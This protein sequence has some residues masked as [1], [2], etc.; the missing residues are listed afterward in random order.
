MWWKKLIRFARKWNRFFSAQPEPKNLNLIDRLIH[1]RK[2]EI[3]DKPL[4]PHNPV[5]SSLSLFI[6]TTAAMWGEYPLFFF[7]S[8]SS[9]QSID[10][11]NCFSF[12]FP[13]MVFQ[14][15]SGFDLLLLLLIRLFLDTTVDSFFSGFFRVSGRSTDPLLQFRVFSLSLPLK[16]I[17]LASA[18]VRLFYT[19]KKGR[20]SITFFYT[21]DS[22]YQVPC[23]CA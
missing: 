23:I 6:Y 12:S 15:S 16:K 14:S 1:P 20:N 8:S 3:A 17:K 9:P 22:P 5:L 4:L 10:R 7:F 19:H 18:V 21:S 13:Q 2:E 11:S